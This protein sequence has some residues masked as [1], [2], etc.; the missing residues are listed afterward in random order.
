M[1]QD[2]IEVIK[3]EVEV[4]EVVESGPRGLAGLQGE[5]GPAGTTDYNE[6]ENVPSTFPPSAHTHDASAITSGTIDIARLPTGTSST[7]VAIGNHTHTASQITNFDQAA[8]NAL[9]EA[10]DLKADANITTESKTIAF[11]SD[12]NDN[13][14]AIGELKFFKSRRIN[15]NYAVW[16]SNYTDLSP[17]KYFYI[18]SADGSQTYMVTPMKPVTYTVGVTQFPTWIGNAPLAPDDTPVG[19]FNPHPNNPVGFQNDITLDEEPSPEQLIDH[20]INA[21]SYAGYDEILPQEIEAAP[22]LFEEVN[23]DASFP[24]GFSVSP[25]RNY[26]GVYTF[27]TNKSVIA[28]D[29]AVSTSLLGDR[30]TYVVYGG[31][32]GGTFNGVVIPAN[33]S[34]V[35]ERYFS[36]YG[37]VALNFGQ[38]EYF[39]IA[40]SNET[41]ALTTGAAKVTFRVP[42]ILKLVSVSASVTVAPTG[43]TLIVDVNRDGLSMLF[44]KLS[45]DANEKT[46]L[47][48]ETPAGLN[49]TTLSIPTDTEITIDIDQI[50][51]TV[52]GAG[53]KVVLGVLRL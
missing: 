8:N 15:D 52:A 17:S 2:V 13:D 23:I 42:Y 53:L 35:F 28:N 14:E 32:T 41:T 3:R 24:S 34:R 49:S 25:S 11:I 1:S 39:V 31:A 48:S 7:Q 38:L 51:S 16:R 50:G 40:C 46:S 33:Q 20:T 45:I 6:L 4:I 27:T 19:I 36:T 30:I 21:H 22:Q 18:F 12:I 9:G 29:N 43:S 44:P 37:W 26:Y 47:T 5:T 10:L